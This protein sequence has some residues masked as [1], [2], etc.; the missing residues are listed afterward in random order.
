MKYTVKKNYNMLIIIFSIISLSGCSFVNTLR[1]RNAN[2]DIVPV[3]KEKQTALL[4]TYY[5]GV[6]PY[7]E[8]AIN[9]VKGF[10][11]LIDTG[12]SFSIL[13]D[14]T[15]VKQLKLK[16]GYQLQLHGWGDEEYSPAY[17]TEAD[18]LSLAGVDFNDVTFAFLPLSSSKYYLHADEL[19]FDGVLGHDVLHHFS[20]KF[21]KKNNQISII[22]KPYQL[23]G[24][25]ISLPFDVSLSKLTINS[26]ID[27]GER[28]VVS[29][30]LTIDTGSRHYLKVNAAFINNEK[31]ML[32][33]PQ[34][35]AADFGLSGQTIHQRVTLPILKLG[36]LSLTD[37]KTNVIGNLDD[38]D[39]YWV[40]GSAL[41]NQFVTVIDYHASMLHIIPYVGLS[42][43]SLYNLLG[44]ELRKLN[45]GNFIVRY[46]FPQMIA[47]NFDFKK[48][49]I[50]NQIDGKP[51]KDI[52]LEQWLNISNNV[53][54]H[55]IC[56][57]R[58]AEACFSME[59]K[60]IQGYSITD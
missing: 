51:S 28:Q 6:K 8:V 33:E 53:G 45:N 37:V 16:E 9:G 31:I 59:S 27:F 15:K 38:D 30:E 42:Y 24:N 41:L 46:I 43:K 44:L 1:I 12:A 26:E 3:W 60:H 29:Q 47:S 52:S 13:M 4:K 22:K 35:T 32:P 18:K 2:D 20:W 21:D 19:I 50:I 54:R 36:N 57:I 14:T 55:E 39:E 40:V 34:L 7:V 58:K 5:I 23:T 10:K 49:D 11:F 17:Q 48:G 25:E 56:R